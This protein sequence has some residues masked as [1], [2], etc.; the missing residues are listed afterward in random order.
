MNKHFNHKKLRFLFR[1][2]L[3]ELGIC[4]KMTKIPNSDFRPL[5]V[6]FPEVEYR[7]RKPEVWRH[8]LRHFRRHRKFRRGVVE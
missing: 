6:L 7:F 4:K 8:F 3:L 2:H 1:N 5:P